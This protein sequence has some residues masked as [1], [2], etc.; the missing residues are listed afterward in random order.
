MANPQTHRGRDES[1][2]WSGNPYCLTARE[3]RIATLVAEEI[4]TEQAASLLNMTVGVFRAAQARLLR[5]TGAHNLAH[6]NHI[7]AT[8]D[9]VS[10]HDG[11]LDHSGPDQSSGR[12]A[13]IQSECLAA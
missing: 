5:K 8:L 6:L 4:S 12:S 10:D 1:H 9:R 13:I 7:I 3:Q 11:D 2:E